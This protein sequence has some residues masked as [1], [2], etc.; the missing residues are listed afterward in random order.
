MKHKNNTFKGSPQKTESNFTGTYTHAGGSY[1]QNTS[2]GILVKICTRDN[3]T[4]IKP[5]FYV[6][7][8]TDTGK[9]IYLSSLYPV[10]DEQYKAEISKQYFRVI[11]KGA[12]LNVLPAK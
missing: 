3:P 6:V 10:D 9:F 1:F 8:R 4:T 7:Q 2:S 5:K 11:Y 12:T